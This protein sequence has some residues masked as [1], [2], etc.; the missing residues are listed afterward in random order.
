MDKTYAK[1]SAVNKYLQKKFRLSAEG[2]SNM[3]KGIVLSAAMDFSFM[4]PMVCV[5]MFLKESIE[6]YIDKTKGHYNIMFY[7]T[8]VPIIMIIMFIINKAQYDSV[9]TSTYTET[10]NKRIA[11]S[12]HLRKIPLAFFENRDLADFTATIMSD[13]ESMEHAYSHSVPQFYGNI[14]AVVIITILIAVKSLAMAA[15]VIW[16]FPI[17]IFLINLVKKK[18]IELEA[19]HYYKKLDVSSSIQEI[20]ENMLAIKGFQRVEKTKKEF[21]A[22]L[23]KEEAQHIKTEVYNPIILGPLSAFL[24]L[25]VL[26]AIIVGF[27]EYSSGRIDLVYYICMIIACGL[28]YAPMEACLSFIMEFIYVEIPARRMEEIMTTKPM[29][30]EEIEVN[31]YDIELNNVSFGYD[32]RKV[33]DNLSLKVKQGEVTALVGPSGCGKSTLA[34]LMLRF[35]D[36]D[37]GSIKLGGVDIKAIEPECLLKNYSA[38]FQNVVLFDNTVMENIRI[39]KKDAGD[40]EVIEA[41]KTA[42]A[43]EFIRNLPEGYNTRIGEN[44]VL[45][46]GGERQRISIARAV[47]KDSPVIFLDES[48]ASVDADNETKLQE[49]LSGLIKNKTVLVIAHR[50]RTVEQ[51]DHIAV[52]NQGKLV[53]EGKA[54]EL[55]KKKGLFYKLWSLQRVQ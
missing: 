34:R 4:L 40:E 38:V 12:N 45:L 44:G 30:G 11:L 47:L 29:A 22:L 21:N 6:I 43:D 37:S 7:V 52:I 54:E 10:A 26:S 39:G 13:M 48:T 24:R 9:Y 49:A 28:I 32:D 23:D 16:P 8:A 55:I 41:A 33:I 18:K 36:T 42:Q 46:S 14:I 1:E 27:S 15:A 20:I 50:L 2:A 17:V 35:W 5:Y 53:E 51:A 25:G 31:N 19:E 3:F